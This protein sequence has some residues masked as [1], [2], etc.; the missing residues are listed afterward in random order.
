[1]YVSVIIAIGNHPDRIFRI[2][3]QF[4]KTK[5]CAFHK[6][7]LG[8]TK[9]VACCSSLDGS[10]MSYHAMM[11][12]KP[13][14]HQ[15]EMHYGS[16]LPICTLQRRAKFPTGLVQDKA[17]RFSAAQRK[18]CQ[19]KRCFSP[20]FSLRPFFWNVDGN[21]NSPISPEVNFFKRKFVAQ[22]GHCTVG[23]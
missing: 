14:M 22:G 20:K 23:C 13:T 16:G 3:G 21:R 8:R 6:K 12:E 15:E 5:M 10:W 7:N 4:H 2:R 17:L 1:M 11:C 19:G 18:R 9:D